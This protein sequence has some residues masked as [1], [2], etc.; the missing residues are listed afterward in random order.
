MAHTRSPLR[1]ITLD[2]AWTFCMNDWSKIA[3]EIRRDTE[4]NVE[5]LK[6]KHT[7]KIGEATPSAYCFFCEY[8]NQQRILTS[9]LGCQCPPTLIDKNFSC[10]Q[11]GH[12]F[13]GQPLLFYK[14]IQRI[15]RIYK[16][17]RDK[18]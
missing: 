13:R 8:S 10:T 5:G 3:R 16:R 9:S 14:E 2:E 15:Y 4:L 11:Q 7:S 6:R 18:K 12:H 17:Q 1:A